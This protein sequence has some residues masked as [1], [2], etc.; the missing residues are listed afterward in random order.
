MNVF[1]SLQIIQRAQKTGEVALTD[2]REKVMLELTK[3]KKFVY[4]FLNFFQ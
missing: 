1:F 4:G 2:K 3:L